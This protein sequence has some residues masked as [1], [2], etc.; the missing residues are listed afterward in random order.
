M[1]KFV[2]LIDLIIN[3]LRQLP[4]CLIRLLTHYNL[5]S[6]GVMTMYKQFREDNVSNFV[7]IS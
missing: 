1:L 2:K 5:L 7:A 4:L 6:T 3:K